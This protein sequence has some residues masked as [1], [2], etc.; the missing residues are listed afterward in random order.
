[1]TDTTAPSPVLYTCIGKGGSY[2]LIGTAR[3]AGDKRGDDEVTVYRDTVTGQF[4]YRSE[5]DFDNRMALAINGSESA[6]S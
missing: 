1:M 5:Q 2:H 3:G 4:Y 6:L